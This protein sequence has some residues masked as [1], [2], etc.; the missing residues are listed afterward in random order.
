MFFKNSGIYVLAKFVPGIIAFVALA[1][2]THLL[3][4]EGY[5]IYTLIFSGALFLH[6]AIFNWLPLGRMRFWLG[7]D[8][9]T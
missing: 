8:L 5:G 2:Y 1:V 9:R 3:T 7:V 4:S 6:S